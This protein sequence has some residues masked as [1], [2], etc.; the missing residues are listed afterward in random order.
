MKKGREWE[1]AVIG[2]VRCARHKHYIASGAPIPR[3]V[4]PLRNTCPTATISASRAWRKCGVVDEK[5]LRIIVTVEFLRQILEVERELVRREFTRGERDLVGKIGKAAQ[6][7]R[8]VRAD[9]R[10][11]VGVAQT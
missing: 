8:F 1:D 6:Q 4:S 9:E 11:H 7:R 10:R 3:I 2:N 5:A